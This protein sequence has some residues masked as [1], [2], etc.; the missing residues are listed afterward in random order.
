MSKDGTG[1]K[2][3]GR[4]ATLSWGRSG[5]SE[6]GLEALLGCAGHCYLFAKATTITPEM[7]MCVRDNV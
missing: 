6:R 2:G 5:R 4:E 3:F 7:E 1:L